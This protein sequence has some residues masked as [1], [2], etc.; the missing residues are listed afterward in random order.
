MV[1]EEEKK[2]KAIKEQN[3]KD[4]NLSKLITSIRWKKFTLT[5]LFPKLTEF[6]KAK[7]QAFFDTFDESK[8]EIHNDNYTRL[9]WNDLLFDLDQ[10][11]KDKEFVEKIKFGIADIA[12][13]KWNLDENKFKSKLTE[14]IIEI[15]GE[16]YS[17]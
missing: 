14:K 11:W 2:D 8:L 16:H 6:Q 1:K 13:D 9:D 5:E 10:T 12:D 3:E 7:Y 17:T 4:S 15:I